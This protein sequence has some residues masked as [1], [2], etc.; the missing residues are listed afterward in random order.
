[1]CFSFF[2]GSYP[3]ESRAASLQLL[4]LSLGRP[5]TLVLIVRRFAL[6]CQ[7]AYDFGT[8]TVS[9]GC[10]YFVVTWPS[11]CHPPIPLGLVGS[12]FQANALL[13][14]SCQQNAA[15]VDLSQSK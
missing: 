5:T 1:M 14:L 11:F 9:T 8:C 4:A 12:L 13:S 3:A 7:L 2:C 15:V 6:R 10:A